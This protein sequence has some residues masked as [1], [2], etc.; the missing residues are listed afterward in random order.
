M[1]KGLKIGLIILVLFFGTSKLL[2]WV[3]ES[4]FESLINSD[5]ERSYNLAY[6]EFDLHNFFKGIT[7]DKVSITPVNKSTGTI[8]TG[9]VDY[10]EL[11]EEKNVVEGKSR[12]CRT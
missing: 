1:K 3:L 10:A 12:L 6:E 5:P 4:R 7:L 9:T 2:E 8:V 11:D